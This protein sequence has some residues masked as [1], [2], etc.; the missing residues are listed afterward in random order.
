MRIWLQH[1]SANPLLEKERLRK[2]F[3]PNSSSRKNFHE[4]LSGACAPTR[5]D[6]FSLPAAGMVA[7]PK[8]DRETVAI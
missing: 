3:R 7:R 8:E 4:I 2:G 5:F 1:K 6:P